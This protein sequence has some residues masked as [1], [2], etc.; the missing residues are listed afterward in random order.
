MASYRSRVQGL[1]RLFQKELLGRVKTLTQDLILKDSS[2]KQN[3]RVN[4]NK[5][6]FQRLSSDFFSEQ[7]AELQ[8]IVFTSALK[9]QIR[10]ELGLGDLGEFILDD[11]FF[12]CPELK[13]FD[14]CQ[15]MEEFFQRCEEVR[16][17]V[18]ALGMPDPA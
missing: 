16:A 4:S 14:P 10:R 11:N 8:K 1:K 6:Q 15:S 17:R 3:N 9:N 18:Q 12:S 13:G 7:H 5:L 2:F